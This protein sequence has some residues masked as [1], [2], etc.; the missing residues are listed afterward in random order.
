ML[1]VGV[2]ADASIYGFSLEEE[3]LGPQINLKL[4]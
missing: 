2:D 1:G 3:M 4:T